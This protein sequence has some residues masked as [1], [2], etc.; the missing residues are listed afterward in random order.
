MEIGK[1][2]IVDQMDMVSSKGKE[3]A[4]VAKKVGSKIT[5]SLWLCNWKDADFIT[6]FREDQR[7]SMS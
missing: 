3:D 6:L 2:R 7:K 1:E 4:G 5:L